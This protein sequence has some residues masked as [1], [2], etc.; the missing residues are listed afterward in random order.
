MLG[1]WV[2]LAL[3][4][5]YAVWLIGFYEY[6]FLDGVNLLFHEA[7][8]LFLRPF[9]LTAHFL[10]GTLFQLLFPAACVVHFLRLGQRYEACVV[11]L[12]FAESL[13]YVATYMADA[14][15]QA[16]PLVGGHIHDWN[17][18]LT[19]W[20][21]LAQCERLGS[22]LHVVA[23]LLALGALGLAA[24]TLWSGRVSG[25]ARESA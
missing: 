16:L 5:P 4:V 2:L 22:L 12:W 25:L 7:G 11:G 1:R 19:R 14:R 17:W 21:L 23:S 9:G 6:H 20:G 10:G 8:H 13:M 24:Q 15:D 18:L 3:L